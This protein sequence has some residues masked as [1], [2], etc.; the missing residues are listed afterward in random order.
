MAIRSKFD[1]ELQDLS[2]RLEN[3]INE[4]IDV[5][6][7][8]KTAIL[9]N[10][11]RLAL[12]VVRNDQEINNL[13]EDITE[14]AISIMAR[15]QPVAIDLRKIITTL[16]ISN[17]LERIADYAVNVAEYVIVVKNPV[18]SMYEEISKMIDSVVEMLKATKEALKEP[19]KKVAIKIADMDIEL[20]KLY[21]KCFKRMVKAIQADFED[22]EAISKMILIMKYL[23]RAGDHITNIAEEIAYLDRGRIYEFNKETGVKQRLLE[24]SF[25]EDEQN[26]IKDKKK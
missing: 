10:N 26:E 24:Q 18:E 4:T 20:D 16:R 8:A 14:T 3:L 13:D 2:V 7:N 9:T 12:D 21:Y 6:E 22:G 25:L 1:E 11:Q 5:Y 15:Q 17:H 23:E 19:S